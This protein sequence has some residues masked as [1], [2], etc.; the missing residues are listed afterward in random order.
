[1]SIAESKD[2]ETMS[3]GKTMAPTDEPRTEGNTAVEALSSG[4]IVGK[5]FKLLN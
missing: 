1:M 5:W 3:E 2:S 4:A